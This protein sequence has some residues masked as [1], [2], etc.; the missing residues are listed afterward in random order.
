MSTDSAKTN[1]EANT[2]GRKK[3]AGSDVDVEDELKQRGVVEKAYQFANDFLLIWQSANVGE[4]SSDWHSAMRS[5]ALTV[6][7]MGD[8]I[9]KMKEAGIA[10]DGYVEDYVP[11]TSDPSAG[12][13]PSTVDL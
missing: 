2:P 1:A 10:E 4:C 5:R 13:M 9:F 8:I 3:I 12:V 6:T 11:P 7:S